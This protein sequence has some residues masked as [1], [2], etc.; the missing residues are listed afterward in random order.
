MLYDEASHSFMIEK[1]KFQ[2][3]HDDWAE[4]FTGNLTVHTDDINTSSLEIKRQNCFM[5]FTVKINGYENVKS[6]GIYFHGPGLNQYDYIADEVITRN[7]VYH[8]ITEDNNITNEFNVKLYV[9]G[10]DNYDMRALNH[11]PIKKYWFIEYSYTKLDGST[12]S[13]YKRY[14][15]RYY[16]SNHKYNLSAEFT[17]N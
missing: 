17:V 1:V 4:M 14:W 5:N 11:D 6:H 2:R 3:D 9:N 10:D 16:K 7:R 8:S 15:I 13:D 12:G